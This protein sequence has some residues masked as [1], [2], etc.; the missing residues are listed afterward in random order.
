M[1]EIQKIISL[2]KQEKEQQYPKP[3]IKFLIKLWNLYYPENKVRTNEVVITMG[4]DI[5]DTNKE[6]LQK[7]SKQK[8]LGMKRKGIKNP[9]H[10]E[11]MKNN[12]PMKGKQ[13]SEKERKNISDGMKEYWRQKKQS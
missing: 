8:Y 5:W 1:E 3:S 6:N 9:I 13:R 2:I 7:I 12:S 11:W 4:E 10:S